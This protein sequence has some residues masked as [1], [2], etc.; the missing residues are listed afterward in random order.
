MLARRTIMVRGYCILETS[1]TQM[2]MK[3]WNLFSAGTLPQLCGLAFLA[4]SRAVPFAV[5]PQREVFH[6]FGSIYLLPL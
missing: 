6:Q 3:P 4:A 1:A 5:G 2:D